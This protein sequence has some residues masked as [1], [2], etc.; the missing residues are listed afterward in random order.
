MTESMI[1]WICLIFFCCILQP[2][3]T[4]TTK[5]SKACF[6]SPGLSCT[7][8]DISCNSNQQI[9]IYDA[10][11]TD[12]TE[13]DAALSSC[14]VNPDNV[15]E[16][17]HHRFNNAELVSLY[18]DCSTETRCVF[19]APRRGAVFSVVKY[20]CIK[21]SNPFS[22]TCRPVTGAGTT[23]SHIS[24]TDG[25][26]H[27]STETL[28]KCGTGAIIGGVVATV[29]AI[30]VVTLVSVR[31]IRNRRAKSEG[32]ENIAS[33]PLDAQPD[34]THSLAGKIPPNN[35][36]DIQDLK[37]Q[38]SD[39]DYATA[40]GLAVPPNADTYFM[41]EP[42]GKHNSKQ[43]AK[44]S[45]TESDYDHIGDKPSPQTSDYD[46]TASVDQHAHTGGTNG[47]DDYG[48]N[49][50]NTKTNPQKHQ[51]DYDTAV[52]ATKEVAQLSMTNRNTDEDD[53]DH[54]PSV[55]NH[56]K[57]VSSQYDTASGRADN[58]DYSVAGPMKG[59]Y[60]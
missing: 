29:L 54:F 11:Y 9:A 3:Y 4:G 50:F 28:S 14:T 27:I 22:L 46:T 38:S 19:P 60:S 32:K 1:I 36:H 45:T 56:P 33:F 16:H 49:L 41:I 25:N 37:T 12:N 10:Y 58:S 35:C 44:A 39:Y 13:C 2:C 40:D 30:L 55:I 53:Y 5:T 43:F 18:N 15:T 8:H 59:A 47:E 42:A 51:N 26:N 20:Q 6:G 23:I 31:L 48:Y 24:Q 21:T 52:S 17:G 57:T 7:Q 34:M